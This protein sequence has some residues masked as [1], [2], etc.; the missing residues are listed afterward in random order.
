LYA[1]QQERQDGWEAERAV[2]G[3]ILRLET[4]AFQ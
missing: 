4:G 3:E 2:A 1:G